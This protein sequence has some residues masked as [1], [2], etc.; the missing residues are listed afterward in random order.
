V[1]VLA[2]RSPVVVG[3]YTLFPSP[4]IPGKG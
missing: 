3:E 2:H 1:G 4:G